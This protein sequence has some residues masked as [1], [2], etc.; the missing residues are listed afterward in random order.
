MILAWSRAVIT[1]DNR[2]VKFSV[3]LM[4]GKERGRTSVDRPATPLNKLVIKSLNGDAVSPLKR[5]HDG[6]EMI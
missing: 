6:K 4:G 5:R 3:V 2:Y 1:R